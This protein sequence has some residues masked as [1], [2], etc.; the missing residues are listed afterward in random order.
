[1]IALRSETQLTTAGR[2]R[3]IAGGASARTR[4][5]SSPALR[6]DRGAPAAATLG[7]GFSRR[8]GKSCT[9][10]VLQDPHRRGEL[11]TRHVMACMGHAPAEVGHDLLARRR[12]HAVRLLGDRG[13]QRPKRLPLPFR[14]P[15][16]GHRYRLSQHRPGAGRFSA[17]ARALDPRHDRDPARRWRAPF[18][19]AA[20]GGFPAG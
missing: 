16:L 17:F 11:G 12:E 3:P 19:R 10:R 8:C 4:L 15:G 1:M 7:L 13:K 6:F 5:R 18:A 14:E 20:A 9:A 2:L